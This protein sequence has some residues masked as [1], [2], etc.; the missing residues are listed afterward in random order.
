MSPVGALRLSRRSLQPKLFI[1]IAKVSDILA[2]STCAHV[3]LAS[4]SIETSTRSR[5]L[6]RS[7]GKRVTVHLTGAEAAG[8]TTINVVLSP[9]LPGAP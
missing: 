5:H 6:P 7:A 3:A 8:G 2:K 1:W 4:A 9:D